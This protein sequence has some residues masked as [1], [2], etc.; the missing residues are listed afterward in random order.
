[1]I[2]LTREEALNI[3]R[4][5]SA[6]EGYLMGLKEKPSNILEVYAFPNVDLLAKKLKESV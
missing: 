1:M 5:L 2:Q 4:S 6:I 3:L